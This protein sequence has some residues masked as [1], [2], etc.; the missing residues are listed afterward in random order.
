LSEFFLHVVRPEQLLPELL[1]S[2]KRRGCPAASCG[3]LGMALMWLG[4]VLG[5]AGVGCGGGEERGN[6]RRGAQCGQ[7]V[8]CAELLGCV[9][10]LGDDQGGES[11]IAEGTFCESAVSR[12]FASATVV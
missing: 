5:E 8:V 11:R 3:F 12:D 10:L 1:G 9:R 6:V 4:M 7:G 2:G